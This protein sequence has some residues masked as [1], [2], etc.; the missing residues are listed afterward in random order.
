MRYYDNNEVID[1]KQL[2]E[3]QSRRL[4]N[5]VNKVYE[6]VEHYRDKMTAAAI[7]PDDIRSIE[8][9][10]RLPFTEKQDL[11]DTYPYGMFAV[12]IQNI[13]RVHAS[14]GTTGKPTVVGYTEQ[15]LETW[16]IDI[17]RAL[18]AIGA[19]SSDFIH[20]SY[21][22]GLFT[23]GMGMNLGAEKIHAAAIPASTG[24]T[25]RQLQV[26]R[27]F[28]STILCCTPSYALY[29]AESLNDAGY[30]KD[31]ISLR[32][33]LFG[34]EPWSENMRKDIEAKLGIKAYDIY[35]IAEIMGPG[36]AYECHNQNG[37]H[38]SEDHFLPEI[39]DPNTGERL[40]EGQEG[41]L[42]IT[43]IKKEGLPLIRYRTR[44]I[45]SLIYEPCSCGRTFVRM[46][47]PKGRTD[48]MLIIRGVNVFPSQIEEVLLTIE[49]ILPQ[50]LIVVDRIGNLDRI[51]IQVELS[52]QIPF[53]AV[54]LV[55]EKERNIKTAIEATLGISVEVKLVSPKTLARSEGKAVRVIDNRVI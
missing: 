5:T 2:T 34:A 44:D 3:I 30:S 38:I 18:V 21:G 1:R 52:S 36:V 55:E 9:L 50:Y 32:A 25:A 13:V 47:K 27:D 31:D 46:T 49:G 10:S 26:L 41:E 15:D 17:A 35:G 48:D 14:S 22:Y 37:M 42:V 39:I 51:Q 54:R 12:N 19:T 45:A 43:C 20:I 40:P 33:G 28:A 23:G 4:I 11:R 24:N 16:S 6:N 8:D 29:L 7:H 53:D